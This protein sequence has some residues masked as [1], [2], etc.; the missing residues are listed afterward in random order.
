MTNAEVLALGIE[1][2]RDW[3]KRLIADFS[4]DDWAFQPD[5]GMGHGLWLCGHLACSQHL[6]VHVRVL[7]TEGVLDENFVRHFPI[8]GPV[9]SVSEH[10]YPPIEAVLAKLDEVHACTIEV[11]RVMSD[12]MLSES[13]SGAD[14]QPHPHYTDKMGAILHCGRHEA[15]HAGQLASI[16]RL[17]GKPFLR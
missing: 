7:G 5:A 3:T 2:T 9:K 15:F 11:V 16:R 10:A 13:A 6:L 4:G 1:G 17:L 12:S 14:G 8:G